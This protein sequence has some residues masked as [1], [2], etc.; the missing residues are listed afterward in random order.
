[1]HSFW[2]EADHGMSMRLKGE[3]IGKLRKTGTKG[4]RD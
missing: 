2:V 4:L 3:M 1:V